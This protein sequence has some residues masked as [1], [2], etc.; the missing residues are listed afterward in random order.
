MAPVT[1]QSLPAVPHVV[2]GV[3][4][5]AVPNIIAWVVVLVVF[6]LA[7]T[8]RIPAYFRPAETSEPTAP[9]D[10]TERRP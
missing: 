3:F 2:F 5:L 7:A 8:L 4:N 6:L 9:D 10:D 1:A